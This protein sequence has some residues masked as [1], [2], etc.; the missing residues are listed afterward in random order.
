MSFSA[1]GTYIYPIPL[2]QPMAGFN[3]GYSL[4]S[5]NLANVVATP[6]YHQDSTLKKPP[7][8]DGSVTLTLRD[9][10][11]PGDHYHDLSV[12]RLHTLYQPAELYNLNGIFKYQITDDI[13]EEENVHGVNPVE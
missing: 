12:D 4:Q 3:D 13:I 7:V 11:L 2:Y 5:V 6:S 9:E 8:T 1:S 10:F